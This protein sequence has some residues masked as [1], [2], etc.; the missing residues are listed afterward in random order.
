MKKKHLFIFIALSVLLLSGCSKDNT[1]KSGAADVTATSADVLNSEMFTDRDYDTSYDDNSSTVI[2]LD[3]NNSVCNSD[4]VQI[5]GSTITI[6]DEGTYI[7]RGIIEDGMIII[8]ADDSD[9]IQLVLDGVEIT[10]KTLAPIYIKQADKVFITLAANS[11]NILVN[12]GEFIAIDDNNIDSVIFSKEDLTLN[13]EGSLT[14]EAPA[15]H[16]IV[17]KDDLVITSGI[18]NITAS[19][20]GLSGKDS[21]RIANG[22][23]NIT[24]G[25]DGIHSENKDDETLGFL[26]ISGGEFLI[27]ADDDGMHSNN[28]LTIMDG[29]INIPS[30]YEGLEG[31]TID[32]YGGNINIISSDD[33]LNA[34]GGNDQS[35]AGSDD[36]FAADSDCCINIYGGTLYVDASGDGIDSNG[37]LT[38][39]DG[40]IYVSGPT[41]GG[42]GALDYNGEGKIIGGTIIATGASQMA[43]NFSSSSTQC[44]ILA[45]VNTQSEGT[46]I[47]LTDA[48][49]KTLISFTAEKAYDSIL[50]SCPEITQG[51]TYTLTAGD[52]ST[53]ITM[54]NLIYGDNG[55][56][57]PGG[58]FGKDGFGKDG[59]EGRGG[60]LDDNFNPDDFEAPDGNFNPDNFEA[61]DGD[62][63]PDD[64]KGPGGDF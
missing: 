42:N 3:N 6:I 18:Y 28:N 34:A 21:V 35:G 50:I 49:G 62:F 51:D 8:D 64:F 48:S 57:N 27:Y 11:D 30:S 40:E 60:S 16:G 33:G 1:T 45:S 26:Y 44:S 13:G 37:S 41:N 43:M 31:L 47:E 19:S 39:Y 59:T 9:K 15:G 5:S 24:C 54:D 7:L 36:I 20:H 46:I 10:S 17:S 52:Y 61:P 14:I 4:S 38:I 53:Q 29:T 56:D 23:F 12:G 25:K 22:T 32:I 63:N 58:A 2:E 55:M